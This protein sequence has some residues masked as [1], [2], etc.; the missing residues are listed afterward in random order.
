MA[1]DDMVR[2]KR[3]RVTRMLYQTR[4]HDSDHWRVLVDDAGF[5][6]DSIKAI[7]VLRREP[8]TVVQVSF[9][10]RHRPSC[11]RILR[12]A[13]SCPDYFEPL[14]DEEPLKGAW[15]RVITSVNAKLY[16]KHPCTRLFKA[17]K[18][19]HEFISARPRKPTRRALYAS[20]MLDAPHWS[21]LMSTPIKD[22]IAALK[23]LK[24]PHQALIELTFHRQFMPDGDK[25]SCALNELHRRMG[26][27]YLLGSKVLCA[28]KKYSS[29]PWV[30]Q[31]RLPENK[32][33]ILTITEASASLLNKL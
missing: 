28:S 18:D 20:S 13:N 30:T 3:T 21:L 4:M 2:L 31:M 8:V 19:D 26:C 27:E 23:L 6:S 25:V 12:N 5:A 24:A 1:D 32:R 33:H 29:D 16:A 7:A 17:A 9:E 14:F 11:H 10:C 22:D 15:R